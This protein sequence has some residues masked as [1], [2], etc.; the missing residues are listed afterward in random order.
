ME[1]PIGKL[2]IMPLVEGVR[3]LWG[4]VVHVGES[5]WWATSGAEWSALLPVEVVGGLV[6]RAPVLP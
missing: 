2:I 3:W 5:Y 4:V 1:A 6:L